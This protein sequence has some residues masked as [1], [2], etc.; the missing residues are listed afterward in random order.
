[1]D[2]VLL[3]NDSP[4]AC[5]LNARI[6]AAAASSMLAAEQNVQPGVATATSA[7]AS[8]ISCW[9][10]ASMWKRTVSSTPRVPTTCPC[11]GKAS[12]NSH[13]STEARGVS[14]GTRAPAA[15]AG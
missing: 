5:L 6:L 15:A 13:V 12:P 1:M 14:R 3:H 2:L 7:L 11:T 9:G 10:D 4:S 8:P